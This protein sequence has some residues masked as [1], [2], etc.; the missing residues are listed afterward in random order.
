[1]GTKSCL[2]LKYV[3]AP[4]RKRMN[5]RR[6]N[7]NRKR[8][9]SYRQHIMWLPFLT[10]NKEKMAYNGIENRKIQTQEIFFLNICLAYKKPEHLQEEAIYF[11]EAPDKICKSQQTF[12]SKSL[13]TKLPL[14]TR[15]QPQSNKNRALIQKAK[16]SIFII[17][18][19]RMNGKTVMCHVSLPGRNL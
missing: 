17:M 6:C 13:T 1:M 12:S 11:T 14:M 15:I 19:K 18:M 9:Q 8:Q 7:E 5:K 2:A 4:S 16:I 3:S 10:H